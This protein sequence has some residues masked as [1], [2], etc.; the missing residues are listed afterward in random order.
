M[1][2]LLLFTVSKAAKMSNMP[3]SYDQVALWADFNI[4]NMTEFTDYAAE[5]VATH[6]NIISLE[7]C[8]GTPQKTGIPTETQFYNTSAH[9]RQYASSNQTKI[10]FYFNIAFGVCDCYQITDSFCNNK[11]MQLKD[12]Y[13]NIVYQNNN[14]QHPY[15]DHTQ[16]YVREWWVNAVTSVMNTALTQNI[17]VNGIFGDAIS[18]Y[19]YNPNNTQQ[20]VNDLRKVNFA[21][22]ET[23]KVSLRSV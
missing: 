10:I 4:E 6:Y 18:Q 21:L 16:A 15:Y 8:L 20:T 19:N 13:G 3:W 5:F 9:I 17:T 11:S 1:L 22:F 23:L 7:K 12:K 2:F 14:K